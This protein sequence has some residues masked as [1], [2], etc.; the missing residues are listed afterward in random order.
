VACKGLNFCRIEAA[1]ITL[2]NILDLEMKK[3][4]NVLVVDDDADDHL[5]FTEACKSLSEVDCKVTSIYKSTDLIDYLFK[6]LV[7][8]DHTYPM[9]DFIVMDVNMPVV[10][11]K[12]L[13]GTLKSIYPFNSL[14]TF[15]LSTTSDNQTKELFIKLG[16]TAFYTK[17]TT[18]SYLCSV[19]KEM[20]QLCSSV[21][22]MSH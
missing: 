16:C 4:V 15:I 7:D 21:P 13:L 5:F 9:P 2:Q 14:P 6:S 22:S 1:F 11:G 10:S 18:L 12:S 8:K 19:V 20:L 3:I 17:G